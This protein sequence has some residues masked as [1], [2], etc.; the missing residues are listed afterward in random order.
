MA[1]NNETYT[2]DQCTAFID[3]S[4]VTHYQATNAAAYQL[5]GEQNNLTDDIKGTAIESNTVSHIGTITIYMTYLEPLLMP[6]IAGGVKTDHHVRIDVADVATID[7]GL[8]HTN[9][10]LV[11]Q[12][13][14]NKSMPNATAVF[15]CHNL[16][17]APVTQAS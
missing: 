13:T 8:C 16:T 2:S 7:S 11:S 17:V 14:F 5:T 4:P 3:D 1:N 6:L 12:V 9:N 15:N 10:N